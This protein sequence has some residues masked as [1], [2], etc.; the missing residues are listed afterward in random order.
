MSFFDPAPSKP[1][2]APSE[3]QREPWRGNS[4]DTLGVPV[5]FSAVIAQNEEV[6]ILVSGLVAFPSG[7]NMSVIALSR[8]NPPL[9]GFYSVAYGRHAGIE[10]GL[11]FGI[12]FPDGSKVTDADL[13]PRDGGPILRST[14]GGR[15]GRAWHSGYWCEPLPPKGMLHFVCEFPRMGISET[16]LE[17]DSQ[18]ILDAA[19]AAAPLWPDD[20][21]LP[22]PPSR[23]R[24]RNPEARTSVIRRGGSGSSS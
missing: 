18:L 9:S 21:G 23:P 15:S 1:D 3:P 2:L 6:A 8:L 19:T 14:G 20:V 5:P 24:P 13:F 12:G 17:M 22:E 7:F 4:A 10:G 11:R 16:Y